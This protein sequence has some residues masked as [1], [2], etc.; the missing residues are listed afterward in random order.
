MSRNK[1][2]TRVNSSGTTIRRRVVSLQSFEHFDVISMVDKLRVQTE[3]CCRF[4]FYNNIKTYIFVEVSRKIV[5]GRKTNCATVTPAWSALYS[6][7][8]EEG[9][10]VGKIKQENKTQINE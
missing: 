7:Q 5:R 10:V 3:N 8:E 2:A 6:Y 4:G 1:H 9:K